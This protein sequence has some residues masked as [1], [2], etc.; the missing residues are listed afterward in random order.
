M[1]NPLDT[2]G[3]PFQLSLMNPN[4]KARRLKDGARYFVT[5]E[6][7]PDAFELFMGA[8]ELAGMVIEAEAQ[9]T[10]LNTPATSP[11]VSGR[12]T[13]PTT[14]SAGASKAG[15]E[16]SSS[17][18]AKPPLGPLAL[19]LAQRCREHLFW[20]FLNELHE[21]VDGDEIESESDCAQAVR[22]LLGVNSRREI[23]ENADAS[24]KAKR[25]MNRYHAW[26]NPPQ[27][28]PKENQD[29]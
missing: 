29:G 16:A 20:N 15:D 4:P 9:V 2:E 13:A 26:L 11:D 1:S 25:L 14:P 27:Q 8:R 5:F 19:W 7:D 28:Q 21:F 18:P 23:D 17:S 24:L 3:E 6:V 22:D 12:S 10:A